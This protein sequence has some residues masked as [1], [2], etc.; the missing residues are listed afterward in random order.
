MTDKPKSSAGELIGGYLPPASLVQVLDDP[1]AVIRAFS[2]VT[3]A[4]VNALD[5]GPGTS[6]AVALAL[7][8]DGSLIAGGNLSFFDTTT[9]EKIPLLPLTNPPARTCQRFS[10]P[11]TDLHEALV[12]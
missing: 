1:N 7:S 8:P 11:S 5:F 2:A 12:C 9:G 3:L 4:T 6:A 10:R